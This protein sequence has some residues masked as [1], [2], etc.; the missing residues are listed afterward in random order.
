VIILPQL[1]KVKVE[2]ILRSGHSD[3]EGDTTAEVLRDLGYP[4]EGVKVNKVYTITLKASN[5]GEAEQIADDMA[6]RLLANPTKDIYTIQ[7][8]ELE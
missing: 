6:R 8:E 2:V 1:Y 7:V 5:P 4:V 3:P